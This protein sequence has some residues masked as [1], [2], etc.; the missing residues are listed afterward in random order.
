MAGTR[1]PARCWVP[2]V[3]T[4]NGRRHSSA[5]MAGLSNLCGK[6]SACDYDSVDR[7]RKLLKT[8]GRTLRDYVLHEDCPL[9]GAQ[10]SCMSAQR[11]KV[12]G[13]KYSASLLDSF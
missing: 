5:G 7:F 13:A 6:Y 10:A 2:R 11:E 9:A 4:G 12:R 3:E 1:R 8:R